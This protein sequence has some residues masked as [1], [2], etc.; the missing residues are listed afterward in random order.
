MLLA[1]VAALLVRQSDLGKP[2]PPD[3]PTIAVLPFAN[4]S[5]DPEQE[6]FSDGLAQE[7][8]DRLGRVPGLAVIGRSSSFSLKG[9]GLDTLAV[10]QRL[11]AT[12]I[13]EGAV[14]RDGARLKVSATLLDGRTGRTIW[15]QSYDRAMTDV[16]AVQ[17]DV[18]AAVIASIAPA[19]RGEPASAAAAPVT[20]DVSAYDLYLLGLSAQEA[21]TGDRA[22]DAVNYLGQALRVDPQFARAHAALARALLIWL[23]HPL[24]PPPAD[25]ERR[26]EAEIYKALALDPS[27][28]EAYASLCALLYRAEHAD[29]EAN[30]KRALDLNPNNT[31][32]LWLLH[33]HSGRMT[34]TL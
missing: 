24:V 27:S 6:Y 15:S 9:K 1:T 16:F 2:P 25:A 13:L 20:T 29:A 4:L 5:G 32:A 18:A 19:V 26:A 22:R 11:G 17:E 23:E 31:T 34:R 7:L 14:R 21:E 28:S 12:T 10:A 8:L 30:C 33:D 3:R